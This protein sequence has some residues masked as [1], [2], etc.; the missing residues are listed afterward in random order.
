MS[1]Q[2]NVYLFYNNTT[3]KQGDA[4]SPILY[5]L[6]LEQVVREMQGVKGSHLAKNDNNLRPLGF[7]DDLYI[8]E[9]YLTDIAT[10][11]EHWKKLRKKSA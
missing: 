3:L 10:R 4:I 1:E 5:N 11:Q 9:N 6:A 8:I 2:H 7:I